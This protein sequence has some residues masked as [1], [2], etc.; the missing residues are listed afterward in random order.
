[1]ILSHGS[2]GSCGIVNIFHAID[3]VGAWQSV[4]VHQ[5]PTNG[6]LKYTYF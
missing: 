5:W 4:A 2:L 3:E 6:R 1:M